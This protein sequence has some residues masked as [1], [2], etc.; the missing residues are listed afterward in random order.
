MNLQILGDE[1]STKTKKGKKK[2]KEDFDKYDYYFRSVQS[3]EN[4][5][6]FFRKTYKEL[7]NKEP[8]SFREDFCGT[9]AIS[10]EWVKLDSKKTAV[11]VDLD[12]EPIE[13][14]DKTYASKL[15]DNQKNRMTIIEGNVLDK[16]VSKTDIVSAS[17]FSYFIFKKRQDLLEYYKTAYNNVDED[18]IF[19]VDCFGGSKCMEANEEETEHE[20]FSYFWDQDSYDP[21]TNYALFHIHFKPDGYKKVKE[22]FTY[23]WRMW[24][25]PEI[26]EIMHEAGFSKVHVY[27]EQSDED[28]DGNGEF[29]RVEMGEECEAWIAYIV[30]E[31]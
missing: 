3:P 22:A 16:G 21:V 31:K 13:Y 12:P 19:I 29:E 8:L 9:H 24:S 20:D 15:S 26:K 11:G 17:N 2:F 5:V 7:K 6:E 14:G 25:I 18:G 28:G 23:D 10:C 30:G 1:M 4:D 27:W